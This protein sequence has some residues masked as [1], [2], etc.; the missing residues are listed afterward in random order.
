MRSSLRGL[1]IVCSAVFGCAQQS[2]TPPPGA[3]YPNSPANVPG[4]LPAGG[5]FAPPRYKLPPGYP[6][7]PQGSPVADPGPA[8]KHLLWPFTM[9][10]RVQEAGYQRRG[11]DYDSRLNYFRYYPK[12]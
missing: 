3:A 8:R 9:L 4:Q 2:A 11:A 10:D 5:A 7:E 1:V 12:D 6:V